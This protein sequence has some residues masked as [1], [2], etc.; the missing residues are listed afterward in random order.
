MFKLYA[1]ILLVVLNCRILSAEDTI[2][3]FY[4]NECEQCVITKE[5]TLLPLLKDKKL[6]YSEYE[7]NSIEN[8][9]LFA[10]LEKYTGDTQNYEAP[11]VFYNGKLFSGKKEINKILIQVL[12]K[13][14]MAF[15][16][17]LPD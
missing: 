12:T 17:V 2:V 16:H 5:F 13:D 10:E 4:N 14:L 9:S 8:Y 7:L 15:F 1:I 3:F 11:I 6:N